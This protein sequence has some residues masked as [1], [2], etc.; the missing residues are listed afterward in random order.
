[1]SAYAGMMVMRAQVRRNYA[2]LDSYGQKKPGTSATLQ[3]VADALPLYVWINQ[4]TE[5]IDSKQVVV[6]T[7]R[8]YVRKDADILRDDLIT[9]VRDRRGEVLFAGPIVVDAIA[10]KRVGGVPSHKVL[11]LRRR[12]G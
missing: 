6:E 2:E 8:A 7:M 4:E 10:E 5:F 9:D 11:M 12:R 3:I 1:M